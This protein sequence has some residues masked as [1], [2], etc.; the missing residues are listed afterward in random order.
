MPK[1][2][3][4]ALQVFVHLFEWSWDDVAKECENW[5][6]P[7]GYDAVQVSPPTASRRAVAQAL[8]AIPMAVAEPQSLSP[9][10]FITMDLCT[11][12]A[13]VQDKMAAYLSHLLDLGVAG[14][15]LDAAKHIA[16]EDLAKIF[17]MLGT[18]LSIA[19]PRKSVEDHGRPWALPSK[20]P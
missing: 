16:T 19:A 18:A 8:L 20:M 13:S 5:L 1:E 4:A 17:A 9:K 2:Q 12:C 6:G 14:V 11:E 15:R 7:K 3:G 10:T